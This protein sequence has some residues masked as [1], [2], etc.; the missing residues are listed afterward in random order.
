MKPNKQTVIDYNVIS[1]L[2]N[3]INPAGFTPTK[4]KVANSA[5]NE[6]VITVSNRVL[7]KHSMMLKK[8]QVQ[9]VG[10]K[11][12]SAWEMLSDE[13]IADVQTAPNP[14]SYMLGGISSSLLTHVE[15]AVKIMG[16]T[17]KSA[18]VEA[19]MDFR[20]EDAMSANW[21]GY[22][23]NLIANI[24][25]ESDESE[26][27]ITELKQMAV[28][29]WAIGNCIKN[30]TTVDAKFDFNGEIWNTEYPC[31]GVIS[32]TESYDDGL[33]ISSTKNNLEPE[34]LKTGVEV[35]KGLSSHFEFKVVGIAESANDKARP[36][37]HKLSVRSINENYAAWVIYAD[38]TQTPEGKDKAPSSN[39]YFSLGTT[40]C[41]MSQMTATQMFYKKQGIDISNYRAEH[42][43]NFQIANFM[44]PVAKGSVDEVTTRI[45]VKSEANEQ[46]MTDFAS[47]SLRMCFAGD[48][49]ANET[50]TEVGIY[51][52]GQQVK[53]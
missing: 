15:Q 36:H 46:T 30:A 47:Q 51:L 49:V 25:I 29:A 18:K 28:Q 7:N 50:P 24:L 20:Y 1:R 14:L 45:L 40:L 26:E 12:F 53:Q 32:G 41:L 38:D 8:G 2:E 6:N 3:K 5:Y 31:A 19:M 37:L 44:S 39:D 35:A 52:N 43:F 4:A 34:T 9:A 27:K 33:K 16:L 10:K 11:G 13:G 23:D 21:S 17:V 22:A 48:A 42:Q